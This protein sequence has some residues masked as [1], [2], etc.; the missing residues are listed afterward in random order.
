MTSQ[1]QVL[2]VYGSMVPVQ[3]LFVDG[4]IARGWLDYTLRR[5]DNEAG[6]LAM[7]DRKGTFT[8]GALSSGIDRVTG[9]L[10]W[11]LYG[12]AEYLNGHL[13][14]YREEGAGIYNLRFDDRELRSVTGALGLRL[15]WQQP[16]SVGMLTGRLRTEWMHEFTSG[17]RQGLD[18]ADVAGPSYYSLM[19]SGWS[20]EQF[21]F[22]PGI[23]LTL[24]SGWDLGLDLGVR[25]ADGERAA[26]TG[27]QVRKKF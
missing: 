9:A 23:G 8:T 17:T 12:R 24:P 7:A 13:A 22:A 10:R 6:A 25:I 20:R 14:G 26:T 18:Y 16:L 21:L 3:G 1:N 4:M 2:A 15:A 5:Q 11:S 19:A 27:V